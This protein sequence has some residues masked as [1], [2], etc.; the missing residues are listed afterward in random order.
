[1]PLPTVGVAHQ[2]VEDDSRCKANQPDINIADDVAESDV[3]AQSG[4]VT[5]KVT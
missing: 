1:M 3:N 4:S 2:L 5:D